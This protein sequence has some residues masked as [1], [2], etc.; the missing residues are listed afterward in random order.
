LKI[1]NKKCIYLKEGWRQILEVEGRVL[2]VVEER[3]GEGRR[4]WRLVLDMDKGWEGG[5]WD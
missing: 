4:G 1:H 5:A 2:V 3:R